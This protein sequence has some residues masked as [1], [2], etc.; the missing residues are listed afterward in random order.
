MLESL[1]FNK[2]AIQ[3]CLLDDRFP[4]ETFTATMRAKLTG[5]FW[6][7]LEDLVTIAK[8]IAAACV[9]VEADDAALSSYVGVFLW[10]AVYFLTSFLKNFSSDDRDHLIL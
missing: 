8:A 5:D 2:S 9:F 4:S 10:L 6:Q 1:L 3:N 7:T